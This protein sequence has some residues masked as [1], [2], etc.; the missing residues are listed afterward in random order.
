MSTQTSHNLQEAIALT[1]PPT[2]GKPLCSRI[3]SP[4]SVGK[5]SG[6]AASSS[7]PPSSSKFMK[8]R[9]APPLSPAEPSSPPPP[10]RGEQNRV[11][12]SSAPPP[13]VTSSVTIILSDAVAPDGRAS[14]PDDRAS[15]RIPTDIRRWLSGWCVIPNLLPRGS[16]RPACRCRAVRPAPDVTGEVNAVDGS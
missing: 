2:F 9:L 13:Q 10:P 4:A 16:F 7:P 6:L 3:G 1:P 8:L 11:S 5:Y 12:S 15:S 14:S